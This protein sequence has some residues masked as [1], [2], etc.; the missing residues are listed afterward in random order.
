MGRGEGTRHAIL[1]RAAAIASR[2]GL[3]GLSIGQL[4]H[5]LALSK[6]GLFAHFQS[7]EALQTETVRFA[8]QVF[9]ESVVRPTL[10]T[11][12]GEPRVR[13]LFERWITWAK[14]SPAKG[15]CFFVS[16]ATE[17]DDREGPARDELLRQQLDWLEMLANVAR[18][19]VGEGHFRQDLDAEQFAHDLNG[20]MLAYHHAARLLRDP[21]A[22]ER[23]E[24]A[25]E[26]LLDRA[27]VFTPPRAANS[28][29]SRT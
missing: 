25:F 18:T 22:E 28:R 23:S 26:A 19:G 11:A 6:S 4:A 14:K 1:E 24:R 12:R 3:D 10:K 2:V 9:V 16:A 17:L 8:A 7:K 20:I 13:A 29:P 27:R 15:G 21:R 5:E